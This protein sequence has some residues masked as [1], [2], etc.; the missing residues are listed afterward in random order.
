MRLGATERGGSKRGRQNYRAASLLEVAKQ[1]RVPSNVEKAHAR[2]T[3]EV[4]VRFGG[5]AGLQTA[6]VLI[7]KLQGSACRTVRKK[8]N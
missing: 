7:C 2:S 3:L 8:D 4:T 1:S 5:A 6:Q